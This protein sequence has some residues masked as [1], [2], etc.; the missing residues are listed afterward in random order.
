MTTNPVT[1]LIQE[2]I[3]TGNFDRLNELVSPSYHYLNGDTTLQGPDQ[4][5]ELLQGFRQA[6]PDLNITIDEQIIQGNRIVTK[7]HFVG[8]HHGDFQGLPATG[9]RVSVGLVIFST[10]QQG[11]IIEEYELIDELAMLQQ[12]GLAA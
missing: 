8:H 2:V 10:I 5:R 6:F 12:L 1:Q 7:A 9:R 4:L 3:N 11:Q